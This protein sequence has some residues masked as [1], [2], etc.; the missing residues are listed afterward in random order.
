MTFI[1]DINNNNFKYI[2]LHSNFSNIFQNYSYNKKIYLNNFF[3]E[4]E[5][6]LHDLI[7][8]VNNNLS[9]TNILNYLNYE[10]KFRSIIR[11]FEIFMNEFNQTIYENFTK[12]ICENKENSFNSILKDEESNLNN[13][14]CS[15]IFLYK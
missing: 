4:H 10:S 14:N 7:Y 8:E 1:S 2:I 15:L 11:N 9:Y 6:I 13:K 5:N 12:L 3:I